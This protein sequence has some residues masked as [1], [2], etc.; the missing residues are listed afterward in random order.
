MSL[1][2]TRFKQLLQRIVGQVTPEKYTEIAEKYSEP[3]RH[4]HNIVHIE[5]CLRELDQ[6]HEHI[7]HPDLVETAIWFHDIIYEPKG[8]D[9]EERSAE[10][11]CKVLFAHGVDHGTVDKIKAMI[12][13][14]KHRETSTD[15]DTGALLDIDLAI[16]GKPMA[17]FQSYMDEIRRE[18]R[19]VPDEQYKESRKRV[20][21]GFLKRR[22]I[23]STEYFRDKYESKARRNL[24]RAIKKLE[25]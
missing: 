3:Q 21:E 16:L 8:S 6:A 12:L 23:Y 20:L 17:I 5:A 7:P 4:Y 11:A 2:E 9:N 13:A 25:L 22:S 18:Y 10:Y 15:Q 19:W 14:T 1:L 24:Q